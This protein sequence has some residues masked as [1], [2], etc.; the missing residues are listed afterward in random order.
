ML[1]DNALLRIGSTH[2]AIVIPSQCSSQDDKYGDLATCY[3]ID[4]FIW[5]VLVPHLVADQV[6]HPVIDDQ[7]LN[8]NEAGETGLHSSMVVAAHTL[9]CSIYT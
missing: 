7:S 1:W 5:N 4:L 6:Y 8:R 2:P 3:C 9:F